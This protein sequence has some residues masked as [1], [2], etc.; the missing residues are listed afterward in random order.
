MKAVIEFG[1]L[2]VEV[3]FLLRLCRSSKV[4]RV[5]VRWRPSWA[6][7]PRLAVAVV[8]IVLLIYRW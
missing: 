3:P 8:I 2:F 1:A 5:R 7:R 6:S 4:I